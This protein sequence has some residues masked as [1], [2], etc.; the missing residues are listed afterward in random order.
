MGHFRKVKFPTLLI[1]SSFVWHSMSCTLCTPQTGGPCPFFMKHISAIPD[2]LNTKAPCFHV[3]KGPVPDQKG[4][5]TLRESRAEP[6]RQAV[7][8][9]SQSVSDLITSLD[10]PAH[11]MIALPLAWVIG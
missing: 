10:H 2:I 8:N 3:S 1:F 5:V 11:S 9:S 7:Q 4:K 6:L